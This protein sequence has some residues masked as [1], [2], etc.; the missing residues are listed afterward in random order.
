MSEKPDIVDVIFKR[1]G[2]DVVAFF[3][4]VPGTD[5]YDCSCY[6]H[7]GQHASASMAYLMSCKPAK[8]AQYAD[9]ERELIQIG[10]TLNIVR[11]ATA[12]H[13]Q[14]RIAAMNCFEKET[15]Q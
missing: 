2:K 9:L 14:Q 1:E 13:R 3:P 11:R 10:Y 4:G 7:M 5:H 8:P 15:E 6:A 12:K